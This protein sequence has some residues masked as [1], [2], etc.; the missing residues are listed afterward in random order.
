MIVLVALINI[1][2]NQRFRTVLKFHSESLS[3]IICPLDL[4]NPQSLVILL[5]TYTDAITCVALA[6]E[7]RIDIIFGYYCGYQT[8]R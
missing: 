8:W 7:K 5:I 3:P 1:E 2:P 4:D 6:Y